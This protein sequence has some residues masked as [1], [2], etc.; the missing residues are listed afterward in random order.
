MDASAFAGV[1]LTLLLSLIVVVPAPHMNFARMAELPNIRLSRSLPGV[2]RDDALQ[3]GISAPGDVYFHMIRIPLKDLSGKIRLGLA[4][5]AEKKVY[6][7]ADKRAHF[8]DVKTVLREISISGIQE[9][10]FITQ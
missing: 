10:S 3:V 9:V 7:V 8:V 4:D 5:G 1:L 6:I 2:M